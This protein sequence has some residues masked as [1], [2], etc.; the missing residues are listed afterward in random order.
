META[1]GRLFCGAKMKNELLLGKEA[2]SEIRWL[3]TSGVQDT[4]GW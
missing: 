2:F 1:N 4:L 3:K